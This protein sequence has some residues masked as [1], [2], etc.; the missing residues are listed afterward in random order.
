[1]IVYFH[2]MDILAGVSGAADAAHTRSAPAPADI[3]GPLPI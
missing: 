3:M 1:V 2:S